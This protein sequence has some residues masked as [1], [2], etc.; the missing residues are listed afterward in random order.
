MLEYEEFAEAFPRLAATSLG[1][2]PSEVHL[3]IYTN[4]TIMAMWSTKHETETSIVEYGMGSPN[5]LTESAS[6]ST[7]TYTAGG[8][9]GVIHQV[10]LTN[11]AQQTRYYYRVGD[12]VSGFS[13]VFSFVTQPVQE[14]T[15]T[16]IVGMFGDMGT[17][18]PAGFEVCEQMEE[19][20]QTLPFNLLVHVGDIAYASTQVHPPNSTYYQRVGN[21]VEAIWDLWA[22]QVQPLA[23]EIL[24]MTTVGN[25]EKFYNFSSYLA[26]FRQP[27]PWGGVPQD[28]NNQTFWYSYDYGRVHYTSMSTEHPWAPGT[29]QYEWLV[30]DLAAAAAN[31]ENVPWIFLLGHRPMY[32]S[33]KDE[34][35][36]HWPGAPLQTQI[37]PL[38]HQYGVDVYVCGHMHM[39]ERINPVLN[40][41]VYQTGNVYTNPGVPVHVVQG[42]AGVFQDFEFVKPQPDWSASRMGKLGYG[43]WHIF[44]ATHI[45]FEF[46][47]LESRAQEDSFWL[48]KTHQYE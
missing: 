36:E 35:S 9:K 14:D 33:D 21:E 45:F 12:A 32:S 24:Y 42:T 1:P 20:H 22:E 26:R 16:H 46:L 48:I 18:I 2:L 7:H 13:D 8:W 43:R 4:N 11:L 25:H 29:P 3:S 28:P 19:A 30:Q 38:M 10:N 17:A 37:E 15:S 6:G 40:G 47:G 39:Y 41:T 34:Q 44:N 23:S 27:D 31:R 5:N